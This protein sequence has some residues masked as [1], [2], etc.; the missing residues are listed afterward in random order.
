MKDF[1]EIMKINNGLKFYKSDLH[2]HYPIKIKNESECYAEE[3]TI[4][5]VI[6]KLIENN[7]ELIVMGH[8][9]SI[10]A[11]FEIKNYIEAN[12][13]L[14]I[15]IYPSI[16]L[17][18]K[19]H[20]HLVIIFP[21]KYNEDQ[22][23]DILVNF[24]LKSPPNRDYYEEETLNYFENTKS[25]TEKDMW[26][27][28]EECK[29]NKLIVLAPHIMSEDSGFFKRIIDRDRNK[30]IR[31]D[32]LTILE[33][34]QIP[35]YYKTSKKELGKKIAQISCSDAHN[36]SQ[37]GNASTWIKMDIPRFKSLQ[38]IIYEPKIRIS[39]EEPISEI[40]FKIIGIM[41]DGGKLKNLKVN[42]NE[43]YNSII[44]GTGSGKSAILDVFKY[45]F[46]NFGYNNKFKKISLKRLYD[47]HKPGTKF[48]LYCQC[49]GDIYKIVREI[50][51][52]QDFSKKLEKDIDDLIENLTQHEIFKLV[53]DDFQKITIDLNDIFNP[54]IFG[55]NELL[56]YSFVPENLIEIF[57]AKVKSDI[58]NDF[59]ELYNNLKSNI[60]IFDKLKDLNDDRDDIEFKIEEANKDIEKSEIKLQEIKEK[61][62]KLE[63]YK[64]EREY[65]N[66]IK[67][68]LK[69]NLIIIEK[70][71]QDLTLE[72]ELI[73]LTEIANKDQ[74]K[75]I[76]K[77][78]EKLRE[79]K[80][81]ID[82]NIELYKKIYKE[83][84]EI[85][86]SELQ[87]IYKTYNNEFNEYC[88][89]NEIQN[90]IEVQQYITQ[91]E[92]ERNLYIMEKEKIEKDIKDLE[93]KKKVFLEE[94]EILYEKYNKLFEDWRR[95]ADLFTSK[96]QGATKIIIES[97]TNIDEFESILKEMDLSS[98]QINKII[99]KFTP[100]DF[101]TLYENDRDI[102]REELTQL[103]FK[104]KTI[105]KII[106]NITELIQYRIK[107]CIDKPS[108]KFF[109]KKNFNF[110]PIDELSTGERCATLLNFV[111]CESTEPVIIDQPEDNIDYNYIRETIKILK[112]QK[113][114]RQFIIVSH[115]QNLP[116][117]ADADLILTMNNIQDKKIEIKYRGS[118]ENEDIHKS[119][120]NLEGGKEA[121]ELRSKK[122]QLIES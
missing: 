88:K 3:T 39:L 16:E 47:I 83:I 91:R 97:I 30:I 72:L 85:Y 11:I 53:L 7:Y 36:L 94:L 35:T 66:K 51:T 105:D 104:E 96:M 118:L 17:N 44:G 41:I 43:N 115:N 86:N 93:Q 45:I 52:I 89:E 28:L 68:N 67:R 19:E 111:F 8:H 14:S 121:F 32:L 23:R 20:F 116:V 13:D 2:I 90:I 119:I 40:K 70:F 37:I 38:Q 5:D 63:I 87:N 77:K 81:E 107:L 62:P 57:S 65:F 9:N 12:K 46:N 10:K 60:T 95:Q 69:D 73:E 42:F 122:Y 113:V 117:L 102:F 24:G 18:L 82:K 71:T 25:V 27:I 6:D 1:N 120:L 50:P 79:I 78:L 103:K 56:D 21:E 112:E 110:F 33:C 4:D 99:K 114:M 106:G 54:V 34:N 29:K 58:Y 26:Y 15:V 84:K 92:S 98:N 101:N 80:N 74:F 31:E 48:T 59:N 61:F 64:K 75:K 22:I 109:L 100:K 76:N 55:Q 108:V 49:L